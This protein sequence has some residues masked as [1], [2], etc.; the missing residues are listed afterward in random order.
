MEQSGEK[1]IYYVFTE[2]ILK[3]FEDNLKKRKKT[4]IMNKSEKMNT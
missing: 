1:K 3:F 4:C 2:N